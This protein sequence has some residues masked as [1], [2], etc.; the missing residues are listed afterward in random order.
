MSC[1]SLPSR[2]KSWLRGQSGVR[3]IN[4]GDLQAPP[5]EAILRSLRRRPGNRAGTP[6]S[7]RSPRTIAENLARGDNWLKFLWS[8]S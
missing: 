6:P 8:P 2:F 3:R 4:Y 5:L 7:Q 1:C